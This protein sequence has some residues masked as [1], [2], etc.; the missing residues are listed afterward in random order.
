MRVTVELQFDDS[1]HF[2]KSIRNGACVRNFG[3]N[4]G[5]VLPRSV[6]ARQN[7]Q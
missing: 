6:T 2:A 4:E 7:K 1:N 3:C 5:R